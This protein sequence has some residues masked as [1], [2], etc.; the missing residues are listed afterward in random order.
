MC[1]FYLVEKFM[2]NYEKELLSKARATGTCIRE[3]CYRGCWGWG[4]KGLELVF[5]DVR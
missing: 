1:A 2:I 4:V 5:P 3:A